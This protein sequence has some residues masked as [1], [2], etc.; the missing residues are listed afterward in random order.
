MSI[1]SHKVPTGGRCCS[2]LTRRYSSLRFHGTLIHVCSR[3]HVQSIAAQLEEQS[4]VWR[5]HGLRAARHSCV[6]VFPP[7]SP[8]P[9]HPA[10]RVGWCFLRPT[11]RALHA[12]GSSHT[13]CHIH[14]AGAATLQASR[15]R[16]IF[17]IASVSRRQLARLS[18]R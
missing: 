14:N 13:R 6:H 10:K 9:H 15:G 8:N 18:Q 4:Q 17:V 5:A 12:G 16:R 11:P 2:S 7:P 1:G 3:E